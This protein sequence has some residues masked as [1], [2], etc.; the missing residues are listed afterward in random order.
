MLTTLAS[1]NPLDGADSSE[2]GRNSN[3]DPNKTII[4][5]SIQKNVF[6]AKK[7]CVDDQVYTIFK[8]IRYKY[9]PLLLASLFVLKCLQFLSCKTF[10]FALCTLHPN[11]LFCSC[12]EG[13]VRISHALQQAEVERGIDLHDAL[14]RRKQNYRLLVDR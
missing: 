8:Q 2:V 7:F 1:E 10:S 3:P 14:H 4:L 13:A 11:R 6:F 5:G 12:D 9:A